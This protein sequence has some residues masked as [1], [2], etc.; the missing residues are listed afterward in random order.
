[1]ALQKECVLKYF[2]M[3]AIVHNNKNS[4]LYHQTQTSGLALHKGGQEVSGHEPEWAS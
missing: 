4:S 1:M 2:Q 3:E